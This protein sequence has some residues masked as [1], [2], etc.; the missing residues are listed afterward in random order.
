MTIDT[1]PRDDVANYV[2]NRGLVAAS[3]ALSATE[4]IGGVSGEV[5]LVE[6]GDAPLVVKR[7]LYRLAVDAVWTAKPER[8]MTE[9]AALQVCHGLT[10]SH[11]PRVVDVDVES[12]TLTMTAAPRSWPTWKSVL[13]AADAAQVEGIA[14]TAHLL[15]AVLGTWHRETAG[16]DDLARRFD[17]YESFEQLRLTPFHRAT[18]QRHPDLA[19]VLNACADELL[20][21]RECLVHGDFSPKN[22]LVG[23]GTWVL[24]FEVAHVGAAVFDLAFMQTHLILKALHR[25][26]HAR[27]LF[28]ASSALHEAYLDTLGRTHLP[29]G[30]SKHT[31]CLLLA[32]LDGVSPAG[33]LDP[34]GAALVRTAAL[35]ALHDPDR[36]EN[37]LWRHV[38]E[39]AANAAVELPDDLPGELR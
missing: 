27:V 29:A 11:T 25:P 23:E 26:A 36:D 9:A 15:G 31:A 38:L 14:A 22:V 7:A 6:G 2:R 12:L 34:A 18:A 33:Y 32:R 8:A 39:L 28:A 17:D 10:P 4:L 35:D 37:E 16:D 13:L 24:D 30:L 5:V 21:A 3:A 1:R 20:Q 19:P